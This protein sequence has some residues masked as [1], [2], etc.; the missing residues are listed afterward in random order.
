M[1]LAGK[2]DQSRDILALAASIQLI[3]IRHVARGYIQA[4]QLHAVTNRGVAQVASAQRSG[5]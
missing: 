3:D 4:S 2:C 1:V 5:R